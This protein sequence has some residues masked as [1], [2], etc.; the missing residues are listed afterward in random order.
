MSDS[1]YKGGVRAVDDEMKTEIV[2]RLL[3]V[4]KQNPSLRLMQLLGNVFRGDP[5][6]VEDYDVLEAVAPRLDP[7]PHHRHLQERLHHPSDT[8]EPERYRPVITTAARYEYKCVE[9][10]EAIF[11]RG[12]MSAKNLEK[13]LNEHAAQGWQ[14]KAITSTDV[15]GR[16][17][18]ET[19]GLMVTFERV[20]Q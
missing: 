18:K 8:E 9:V 19:E 12:G 5:Y 11:G 15:K 14:V 7:A 10:R 17:A 4:W 13:L 2:G 6:Y 20:A 1:W 3:E 16:V